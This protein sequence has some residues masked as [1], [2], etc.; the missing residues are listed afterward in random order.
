MKQTIV[1]ACV[2]ALAI[3]C[4]P[5]SAQ[6]NFTDDFEAGLGAW[7]QG[8]SAFD[9]ST[10][11]NIIPAGGQ[12]SA[13]I[14]SSADR[15][16]HNLGWESGQFRFT[17]YLY[18]DTATRNFGEVRGY[19]GAGYNDGT[20]QQLYA[21]GKYNNVTLPGETYNGTK[22]QGRFLYPSGGWFNLDGAGTP[23]RSTGWHKFDIL[24]T[25]S[26]T[27]NFYVDD[28]LSRSFSG[29]A[30]A[31]MDSIAFGLG[32]GTTAGASYIDGVMFVPEPGGLLA[33][34]AGLV[35]M[36]GLIRRRKA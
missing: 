7:T 5:A 8:P 1:L 18:D 22:Y 32:S 25:G 11:Q 28:V 29:M 13:A 35:G 3:A 16:W 24:L 10:A 31:T 17:F 20:L 2:L 27:V 9:L 33:L 36:A 14:D 15:M 21:I 23:G 4:Q 34:G 12:Y 26:N 6:F 19:S 30:A